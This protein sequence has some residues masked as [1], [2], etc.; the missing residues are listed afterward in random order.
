M[1]DDR[2]DIG[3]LGERLAADWLTERGWTV[4]DRR[5]RSGHRDLDLVVRLAE[6]VA[7]VEVKARRSLAY[8]D[9][10]EAVGWRKRREL[11]RSA[12]VW[13]DRRGRPG[14]AY[15]FDVIGVLLGGPMGA[16]TVQIQHI[17]HAFD[18]PPR[19]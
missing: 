16:P 10:I 13:I 15:R 8:G 3:R 11:A 14:D 4:L 2:Q 9:A 19:A 12:S 7:F 5:Y 6:V 1:A 17:E 18:V